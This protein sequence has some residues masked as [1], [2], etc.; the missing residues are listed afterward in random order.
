MSILAIHLYHFMD[1]ARVRGIAWQDMLLLLPDPPEDLLNEQA[2]VAEEEVY[3]VLKFID[4]KLDDKCWGISCAHFIS[5][6]LL[7]LIYRIS[8]QVTTIQEAL[9]YL[10][11]YLVA[12]V[13]IVAVDTTLKEESVTLKFTI[14]NKASSLN[15]ILLEY[16]LA[17]V[18]RELRMMAG[19]D[20]TITL[21]SPHCND[22]Y[23]A[24]WQ[25]GD[26]YTVVFEPVVLKAALKNT[27]HLHVDILV[28]E[29]LRMIVQLQ[30]DVSFAGKVKTILLSMSNPQLPN[31][32]EVSEALYLTPR[33]LQRRLGAE[34]VTFREVL[35]E[36]KKQICALLLRHDRYSISGISTIL[37][38]AEPA[39]FIH[40]FKKWYGDSPDR[41][42]K[43][44]NR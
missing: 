16:T 25:A 24:A 30:P 18:G 33:T 2:V 35:E 42:R 21:Y 10:Q 26:E 14:N 8:L 1:Y 23:P 20:T 39:A 11:S 36:I 29:Y 7:G 40:S 22:L 12:A 4:D 17:V 27:S 13:P 41:M 19:E 6:K 43:V 28:P 15:R 44:M 34:G 38:Y 37:G 32:Q 31:I 3:A 9:H 5:L